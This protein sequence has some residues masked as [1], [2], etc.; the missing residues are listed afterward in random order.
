M[1]SLSAPVVLGK[2]QLPGPLYSHQPPQQHTGTYYDAELASALAAYMP[3]APSAPSQRPSAAV[4]MPSLSRRAVTTAHNEP[5]LTFVRAVRTG[6]APRPSDDTSDVSVEAFPPT[7]LSPCTSVSNVA[8]K[9]NISEGVSSAAPWSYSEG[10]IQSQPSRTASS[11]VDG[12][13]MHQVLGAQK[14]FGTTLE[15][16][17][18]QWPVQTFVDTDMDIVASLFDGWSSED[19]SLSE[20]TDLMGPLGSSEPAVSGF[21]PV[22]SGWCSKEKDP[23]E[24]VIALDGDLEELLMGL[25]NECDWL[26]N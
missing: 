23:L 19:D 14:M 8:G 25:G 6:I 9:E 3:G 17:S 1:P 24:S 11:T 2:K 20:N 12:A 16:G 4:G 5:A 13:W 26:E 18:G 22:G 15:S 10:I 21:D 7:M